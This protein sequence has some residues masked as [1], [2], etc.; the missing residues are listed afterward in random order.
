MKNIR[1]TDRY[2]FCKKA[3]HFMGFPSWT[4]KVKFSIGVFLRRVQSCL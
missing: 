2:P 3:L 4:I 1:N